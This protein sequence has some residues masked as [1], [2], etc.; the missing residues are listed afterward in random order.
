MAN[1]NEDNEEIGPDSERSAGA[2]GI[3]R[4]RLIVELSREHELYLRTL[5]D[6]DNY[7]RRI[8]RERAGSALAGK[9]EIVLPLLDVL[10]DFNRALEH[11][12]DVPE[13]MSSGF[14]AIYRRLNS[15]LQA[16]GIVSYASLGERFDPMR[17]EAAG[18]T[19]SQDV[20][21]GT[22]VDELSQGYRWG[23][24]VLRPA[25]VRVAQ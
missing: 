10:D 16:Q 13:W 7:R 22:V 17:H 25:R 18:V 24:E 4:E 20:E 9:R 14:A 1:R 19:E 15:I 3:E 8:E 5:A 2:E 6:F 12:G 21:P 23:D 11:L